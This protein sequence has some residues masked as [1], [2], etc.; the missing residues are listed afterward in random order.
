MGYEPLPLPCICEHSVHSLNSA[1]SRLDRG[2]GV[3]TTYIQCIE[4]MPQTGI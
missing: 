3:R 4:V 2:C 1:I